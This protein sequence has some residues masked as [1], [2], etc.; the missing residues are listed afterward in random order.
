VGKAGKRPALVHTS[1]DIMYLDSGPQNTGGW[2]FI[3]SLNQDRRHI[4]IKY[5]IILA[6]YKRQLFKCYS[7]GI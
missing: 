4:K 7:R 1:L 5:D 3:A 6:T 2:T